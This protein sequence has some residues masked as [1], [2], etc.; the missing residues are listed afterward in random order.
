[1]RFFAILALAGALDAESPAFQDYAVREIFSGAPTEP[2]LATL[3]QRHYRTRIRQGVSMGRGVWSGSWKD[4]I[5]RSGP[6]FAGHY[7]VIRWGCGSDCLMMAVVDA[8]RGRISGPPLSGVGT[9]LYVPM[10]PLSDREIDF[11]V[12][13]SLMI[14]RN[15]CK[16]ARS[17]CGIYYFNWQKDRFVLLKRTLIDLTQK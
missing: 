7:Y 8:K 16:E 2:I 6:N 11:R 9:E 12:D 1:V 10:D 13:S 15:A 5:T 4:P 3:E 14:L 17:Q